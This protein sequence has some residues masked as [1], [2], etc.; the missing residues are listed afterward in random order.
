MDRPVDSEALRSAVREV[1]RDLLPTLPGQ[2]SAAGRGPDAGR[3]A[4]ARATPAASPARTEEISIRSDA[5]LAAFV[6]RLLR[7]FADPGAREAVRAGRH[8]F[9]LAA[10]APQSGA[11]RRA[12][13]PKPAVGESERFEQAV[14]CETKVIGL[15]RAGRRIV[16]GKRVVV[17]PLAWDKAR[18]LGVKLERE[19]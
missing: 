10:A 5:E 9:H 11:P 15:A 7:L 3:A 8:A 4:P 2:A 14:L 17:T 18:Q 13:P 1:L 6:Q 12:A 19:K 16:L